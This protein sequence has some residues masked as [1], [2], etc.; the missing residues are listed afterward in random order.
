MNITKYQHACLV[1][2]E[3]GKLLV[4]DPGNISHDLVPPVSD[5][6]GVVI[7][8][9]HPDHCDPVSISSI[10]KNNPEAE[11][12]AHQSVIAE[13]G[14]QKSRAAEAGA[15]LNIGPFNLEFYGGIHATIHPDMPPL[16]NLGV[17]VNDQLYYPG[18]SFTKPGKQIDTLAL[19]VA[20]PWMKISE[21]IEFFREVKPRQAFPTHDGIL[22][23]DG[24]MIVDNILRQVASQEDLSYARISR[25]SI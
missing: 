5:V 11:I 6:A 13:L 16:A 22:S 18:D 23:E 3:S 25:L 14:I 24:K 10:L 12:I 1:V 20:A 8:H 7:T 17:L 15:S 19:P 9:I 21:A 4:I 2:E